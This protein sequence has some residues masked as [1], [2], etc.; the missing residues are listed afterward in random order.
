MTTPSDSASSAKPKFFDLLSSGY[1][2]IYNSRL[3][4]VRR[5]QPRPA[6]NLAALH[7]LRGE[8]AVIPFDVYV[9]GDKAKTCVDENAEDAN[10]SSQDVFVKFTVSDLYADEFE[11]D[12]GASQR[13]VLKGRLISC[14][15][16]DPT[17][18]P[19]TYEVT[20]RG[21]GYLNSVRVKTTEDASVVTCRLVA[22][23]GS[24]DDVSKI[25]FD[26]TVVG[27]EAANLVLQYKGAINGDASVLVG[28]SLTNL[29]GITRFARTG[30]HAGEIGHVIVSELTKL[31]FIKVNGERVYSAPR[32]SDEGSEAPASDGAEESS[33]AEADA[34]AEA[35]RAA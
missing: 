18:L 30:E 20:T 3:V 15:R 17:D 25:L 26:V 16:V 5:G 33:P 24:A 14:E 11:I 8:A 22:L 4:P 21:I 28:F 35:P 27:D 32:A 9:V 29:S 12:G 6:V 2:R 13:S 31:S 7:G 34:D 23:A 10:D 1:G 19:S